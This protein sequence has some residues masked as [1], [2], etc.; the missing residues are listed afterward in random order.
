MTE[1]SLYKRIKL[2]P[3]VLQ[4]LIGEYNADHRAQTK[5]IQHEYFAMIYQSCKIC[6]RLFTA[7]LY[8][9][10]DYFMYRKYKTGYWCSDDCLDAEPDIFEK[11]RYL[12]SIDDWL[13][14]HTIQYR[15]E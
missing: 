9:S 1:L 15:E 11:M 8:C 6:T 14:N 4:D 12:A 13:T 7:D 3:Q 10:V 2:L 5:R